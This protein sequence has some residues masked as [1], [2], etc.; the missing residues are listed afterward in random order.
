MGPQCASSRPTDIVEIL[1]LKIISFHFALISLTALVMEWS[2]WEECYLSN[3][4]ICCCEEFISQALPWNSPVIEKQQPV[5]KDPLIGCLVE[6]WIL[7]QVVTSLGMNYLS[8]A[9]L[10]VLCW[11]VTTTYEAIFPSSLIPLEWIERMRSST[12]VDAIGSSPAVG[13][14]N[15]MTCPEREFIQE[16]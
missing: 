10:I 8:T 2:T 6:T 7:H 3:N 13:S 9:L 12:T 5:D 14:S 1:E 11:W 15:K 16:K 4:G